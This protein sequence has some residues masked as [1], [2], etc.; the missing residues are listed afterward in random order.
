MT[1]AQE[2]W[3]GGSSTV[4]LGP[5]LQA[6]HRVWLQE[7]EGFLSPLIGREAPFWD[8]WVATRYLADQFAAQFRRERGMVDELRPFLAP[9]TAERL[10]QQSERLGGVLE[11]FDR[12]GRMRGTGRA[13]SV[14]ARELLDALRSWCS[15][16]ETAAGEIEGDLLTAEAYRIL[17]TLE[18][19]PEIH[20]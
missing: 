9:T 4:Q 7:A 11:A 13:I 10:L 2:Q 3:T 16:V 14:I 15:D 8:R 19:Y 5:I 12:Q 18:Q 6:A 20:R 17:A 1:V